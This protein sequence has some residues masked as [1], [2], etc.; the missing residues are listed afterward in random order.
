MTEN[1]KLLDIFY[2]VLTANYTHVANDASYAYAI[3]GSTLHIY[4]QWSNGKTDWRNNFDFPAKP[5]RDMPNRWYAH[6]GFV[7]VWKSIEDILAPI[8]NNK[9][10][11][12]IEIAGY[13]HGAAIA[14]LCHEYCKFNRPDISDSIHGYGFGSP[15]VIWG[16]PSKCV[17]ERFDGYTAIRNKRDI[18]T[19]LPPF[20]F[21]FRHTGNVYK[22]GDGRWNCIDAH[23]SESYIT[24][25][26]QKGGNDGEETAD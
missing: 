20:I 16:F 2:A 22:V 25:L 24:A 14:L 19:H 12:H 6:R 5:Y 3:Q 17:L 4:F 1:R 10:V 15:R 18:V 21:G 7:R 23:R 26:S 8:I 9:A 11:R 13:S